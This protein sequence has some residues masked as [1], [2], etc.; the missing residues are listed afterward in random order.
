MCLPSISR[1]ISLSLSASYQYQKYALLIILQ[2]FNEQLTVLYS[3]V[4][5]ASQT[6]APRTVESEGLDNHEDVGVC[7]CV[8]V[9]QTESAF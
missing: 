4:K 1:P 3:N 5:D 6:V 2:L 9:S 8:Y 7:V